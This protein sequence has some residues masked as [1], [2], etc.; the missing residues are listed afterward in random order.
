MSAIPKINRDLLTNVSK[1]HTLTNFELAM[2]EMLRQIR[3]LRDSYNK[4]VSGDMD[5]PLIVERMCEEQMLVLKERLDKGVDLLRQ[6]GAQVHP[7]TPFLEDR[8]NYEDT[9]K[10]DKKRKLEEEQKGELG[11]WTLWRGEC[12]LAEI[13]EMP[14]IT[15][16][17]LMSD[18][19]PAF[20]DHKSQDVE[21]KGKTHE[22]Q[23]MIV[24]GM[25][26]AHL[27]KNGGMW[28]CPLSDIGFRAGDV[29]DIRQ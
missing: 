17:S 14:G 12:F 16:E 11:C 3:V 15:P 13:F 28:D 27:C 9:A 5:C 25:G 19:I 2:M 24:G 20:M 22:H 7:V 10:P 1:A 29:L 4:T 18:C 21:F 8:A 23:M 6:P 26:A